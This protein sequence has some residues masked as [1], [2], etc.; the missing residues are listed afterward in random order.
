MVIN[1]FYIKGIF[2]FQAKANRI[3]IINPD[4]KLSLSISFEGFKLVTSKFL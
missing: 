4:T 1:N 3:L 2:L